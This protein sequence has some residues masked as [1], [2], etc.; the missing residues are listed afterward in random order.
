MLSS[1]GNFLML[2]LYRGNFAVRGSWTLLMFTMG[3][4]AVA[5][6]A[7]E[8]DRKYA[9]GYQVALGLA[10]LVA[11]LRFFGS[12]IFST[13]MLALIGYLADR[14]VYDCTLIDESLDASGQGL[15]DTGRH[16]VRSQLEASQ[17]R[18]VEGE[19]APSDPAPKSVRRRKTH[20]PGRTVMYLA[21][22]ALPLFG[23]G[24]FFISSNPDSSS[25]AMW[26]L[27]IYLFSS[28]SL[29]VTTSF[30]GLRRYLRQR[31]TEMPA[32]VS[33]GWMVGGLGLIAL[34]LIVSYLAP[35]P[36]QTLASF[37]PPGFLKSAEDLT[38]SQFGWGDEATKK[39]S[40]G[41]ATTGNDKNAGEKEVQ[42]LSSQQGAPPGDS[43]DGKAEQGPAGKQKGGKQPAEGS[44]S[45]AD[46]KKQQ[47]EQGDQGDPSD[48]KDAE[49]PNA[50]PP[51]GDSTV[52]ETQPRDASEQTAQQQET[53]KNEN[54]EG[55]R[56]AADNEKPSSS[57]LK[58][59]AN[60]ISMIGSI[61]RWLIM[62]VLM[63]VI[64]VFLWIHRE[65]ILDWWNRLWNRN[66][67]Q[68]SV[69]SAQPLELEALDSQRP[70]SSFRNPVGKEKDPRQVV[71]VTFQAFEAWAR[72]Q[73]ASRRKDETP[74]EFL[75]RMATTLPDVSSAANQVVDAYNRVVYGDGAATSSDVSAAAVVW[76]NMA[77]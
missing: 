75:K 24:Q 68:D 53:A 52:T 19:P 77:R 46:G 33:V 26:L 71:I 40:P 25:R 62:V 10:S 7:I 58:P 12:P 44:S 28:F 1:L 9:L 59:I 48:R 43:G 41:A 67:D 38:P 21:L 70:F 14:I 76:H 20:Q 37:K 13:F 39:K 18:S 11:M 54:G 50:E 42:E 16:F 22:G 23:L 3:T 56:S 8:N 60:V 65:A 4:V 45:S 63:G 49:S 57:V 5:R 29:L 61:L 51:Q 6:V 17:Q 64:G 36:G 15:I 35:K 55:N 72:E 66:R 30:L 47:G 74:T 34:I 27:A 2:V 31:H 32:D 73:G 69:E